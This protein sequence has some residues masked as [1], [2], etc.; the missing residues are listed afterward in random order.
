MTHEYEY[1]LINNI[2]CYA[3]ELALD[4]SDYN[5]V[6]FKELYKLE[7]KSFW[8]RSRNNIIKFLFERYI[9]KGS[10]TKIL[11]I[12]CGTGYV[13]QALAEIQ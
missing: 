3:P 4:N 8:F 10:N 11:E 1:K 2:K 13:L 5:Q 12:G 6:F 7:E 9:D